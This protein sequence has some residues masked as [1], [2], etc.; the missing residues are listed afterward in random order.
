[1]NDFK[2]CGR[3]CLLVEISLENAFLPPPLLVHP[4]QIDSASA[5]SK[6]AHKKSLSTSF[7][8]IQDDHHDGTTLQ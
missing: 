5:A 1:M 8:F 6:L 4:P 7:Q 3:R 2:E